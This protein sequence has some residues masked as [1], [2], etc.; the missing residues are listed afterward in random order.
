MLTNTK[1]THKPIAK[2]ASKGLKSNKKDKSVDASALVQI[3]PKKETSKKVATKAS[4]ELK[5]K[6]TSQKEKKVAGSV[7]S[8][9]PKK[10]KR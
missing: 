10:K 8:Q 5:S 4:K 3:Q 2:I 7:L 1:K 9:T 6:T